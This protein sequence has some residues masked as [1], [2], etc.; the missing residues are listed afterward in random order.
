MPKEVEINQTEKLSCSK[1]MDFG[2]DS[3]FRQHFDE[4]FYQKFQCIHPLIST[5]NSTKPICDIGKLSLGE[6]KQFYHLHN[7]MYQ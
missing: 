6:Q 2:Y 1:D 5:G 3:C 7:G 4:L